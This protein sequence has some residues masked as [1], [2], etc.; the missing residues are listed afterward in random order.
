MG[1]FIPVRNTLISIENTLVHL[2]IDVLLG[3]SIQNLSKNI[4]QHRSFDG[5]ITSSLAHL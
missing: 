5:V 4:E 2:K 3:W 1:F